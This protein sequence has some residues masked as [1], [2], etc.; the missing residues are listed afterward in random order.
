[1]APVRLTSKRT[2]A[3]MIENPPTPRFK[4]FDDIGEGDINGYARFS[5][6]VRV[7]VK[8]PPNRYGD[9]V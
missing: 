1:M 3:N 8:F 2:Y 4:D 9:K 6:C 7:E 5:M